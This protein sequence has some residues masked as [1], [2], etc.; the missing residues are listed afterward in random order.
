MSV[1]L[2][3][4]TPWLELAAPILWA[5]GIFLVLSAGENLHAHKI[6]RFGLVGRG[7]CQLYFHERRDFSHEI[8]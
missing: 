5:P 6:P 3:P 1:K 8:K 7:K 4:A 2:L